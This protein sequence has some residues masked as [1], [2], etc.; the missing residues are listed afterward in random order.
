MVPALEC[1]VYMLLLYHTAVLPGAEDVDGSGGL[2][3][4]MSLGHSRVKQV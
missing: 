1:W 4:V 2:P 3:S